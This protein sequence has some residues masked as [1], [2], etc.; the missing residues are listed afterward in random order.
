MQ[1]II[2]PWICLIALILSGCAY[3]R[4][5]KIDVQ[6]GNIITQQEVSQLKPGM[7][8]Q[9]V[10]DLLGSPVLTNTFSDNSW[11]YVYYM[12]PGYGQTTEQKVTVYFNNGTVSRVMQSGVSS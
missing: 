10:Y 3:F 6:Q 9:Q 2:I 8:Q 4:P 1:K 12:K 11:H 7:T 5:Y